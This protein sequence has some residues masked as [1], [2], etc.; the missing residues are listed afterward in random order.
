M[1]ATC[2]RN[3]FENG[4]LGIDVERAKL[5][6]SNAGRAM[7]CCINLLNIRAEQKKKRG[8]VMYILFYFNHS[9]ECLLNPSY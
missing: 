7:L 2:I 8:L 1:Q 4:M 6:E 9:G 5:R 3:S